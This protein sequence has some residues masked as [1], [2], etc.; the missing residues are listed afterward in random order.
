MQIVLIWLNKR[1]RM[2]K[3]ERDFLA[4]FITNDYGY[5]VPVIYIGHYSYI[6]N[7]QYSYY[8]KQ[9]YLDI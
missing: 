7:G 4:K 1:R 8:N 9:D 2:K 6:I 3:R 5:S